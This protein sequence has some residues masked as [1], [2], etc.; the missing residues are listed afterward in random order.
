[1]G[2]EKR[3]VTPTITHNPET[4]SAWITCPFEHDPD[5]AGLV[6]ED[7]EH[8]RG[9]L[10]DYDGCTGV[11]PLTDYLIWLGQRAAKSYERP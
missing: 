10:H 9:F 1:M 4:A 5:G 7:H 3:T 11:V 2:H 8:P 6:Y